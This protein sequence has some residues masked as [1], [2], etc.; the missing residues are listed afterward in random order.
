MYET[1]RKLWLTLNHAQLQ[2]STQQFIG[3][4]F[5]EM[6]PA[7]FRHFENNSHH[8]IINL[9]HLGESDMAY[10]AKE[11]ISPGCLLRN[12]K[13]TIK[14]EYLDALAF[15]LTAINEKVVYAVCPF[16]GRL[17]TSHHSLLANINVIF[18]RFETTQVFYVIIAGRFCTK[19]R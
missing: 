9:R 1:Y 10:L 18:Y 8:K 5:N 3:N 12:F 6:F 17:V 2:P 11:G 16:T 15:Q 14:G 4:Q 19:F 13:K 7:L